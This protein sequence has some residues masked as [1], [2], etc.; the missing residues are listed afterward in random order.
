[1]NEYQEFDD[2]ELEASELTGEEIEVEALGVEVSIQPIELY[3]VLKIANVVGGGGEAKNLIADGYVAVNG[4]VELR[5]RCK[6][7]DGDVIEFNQDYFVVLCP[8]S[9]EESEELQEQ[10]A[11]ELHAKAEQRE[12]EQLANKKK[13]KQKK[14]T[15]NS[16]NRSQTR[17]QANSQKTSS[18]QNKA[19]K[20]KPSN[21]KSKKSQSQPESQSKDGS[22]KSISFF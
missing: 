18:S 19:K 5:K 7:Y 4:Q 11:L 3:K 2:E 1:M 12:Q 21:E 14:T 6:I 22:R 10:H 20:Q 8:L 13:S 17:S 15:S 16:R 9:I